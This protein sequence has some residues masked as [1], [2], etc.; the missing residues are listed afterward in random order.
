MP[1]Q[2]G[3]VRTEAEKTGTPPQDGALRTEAEKDSG[4]SP[5]KNRVIVTG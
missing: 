4:G 3:A 2:D 1:T 5:P